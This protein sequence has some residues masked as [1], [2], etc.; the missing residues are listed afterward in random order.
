[1][2]I[3]V[4]LYSN[5]STFIVQIYPMLNETTGNILKLAA[6]AVVCTFGVARSYT[7]RKKYLLLKRR[8]KKAKISRLI[9]EAEEL[10][11]IAFQLNNPVS[12]IDSVQQDKRHSSTHKI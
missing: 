12:F 1:M 2:F 3:T 4:F 11:R 8:I 9:K 10:E 5:K 6:L 7:R